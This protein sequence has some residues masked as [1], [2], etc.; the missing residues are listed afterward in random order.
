MNIF[1]YRDTMEYL[2]NE[3][4]DYWNTME[5]DEP[6]K[7]PREMPEEEWD[8]Q[9]FAYASKLDEMDEWK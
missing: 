2:L 6:S 8:E 4:V 9:F 3:F 1:D 5:E 7:F